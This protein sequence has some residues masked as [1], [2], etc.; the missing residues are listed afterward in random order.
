MST[1]TSRRDPDAALSMN[2]TSRLDSVETMDFDF[3]AHMC[4]N[5]LE[6]IDGSD[7]PPGVRQ[8]LG[9]TPHFRSCPA[10]GCGPGRQPGFPLKIERPY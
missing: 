5:D 4:S 1:S 9:S 10:P 3:E 6:K 7:R 8:A 2:D